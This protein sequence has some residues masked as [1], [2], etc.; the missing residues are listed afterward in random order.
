MNQEKMIKKNIFLY[1]LGSMTSRLGTFMYNFAVGIYVLNL[2]GSGTSFAFSI[3]FVML[4]RV[5]LSPFAGVLADRF[6]RKKVVVITD[7]LSGLLLILVFLVS[8]FTPLALW[9]IYMSSALLTIFNTF[10]GVTINA[11][12]PSL[13]SEDQ[14]VSV[15]SKRAMIDSSASL[16]GPL[17]GGLI[18]GLI[19]FYYFLILN[20]ISF[21][22]S[23]VTEMFMNFNV[24]N[25]EKVDMKGEKVLKSIQ[26]GLNYLKK[27]KMLFGVI[28]YALYVNFFATGIM[29]V[30]PFILVEELGATPT[31]YGLV[32][33]GFPIGMMLM[34]MIFPKLRL[35]API[36]I[37]MSKGLM[38]FGFLFMV[39]GLPTM[40]LLNDFS[41]TTKFIMIFVTTFFHAMTVILINIPITTVIQK[42]IED[43][44]QGRVNGVISM[45]AQ[46][47]SPIGIVLFGFLLDYSASY[48]IPLVAGF[49]IIIVGVLLL[50]DKNMKLISSESKEGH[51]ERDAQTI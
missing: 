46:L 15:N 14:L 19:G 13:V 6:D 18:Y 51:N 42:S 48:L 31:Q 39:L 5:V 34:S 8:R 22:I 27:H 23:A 33:M 26:D 12:I 7:L 2:T 35:K 16:L 9:V 10:F 38:L 32:Q 4:P 43:A 1:A 29:V 36:Y 17:L 40:P 47:V 25:K 24:M 49:L 11:S 41:Q 37:T 44:Y 30:L 3:L 45:L 20:G 28:K 50:L 21:I